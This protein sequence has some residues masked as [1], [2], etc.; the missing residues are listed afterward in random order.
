MRG[1][2]R[3]IERER[4]W[5]CSIFIAIVLYLTLNA[6]LKDIL[7]STI[8]RAT[9]LICVIYAIV[10][11]LKIG[12]LKNV[13]HGKLVLIL[14]II[15]Q[16]YIL[17]RG[18][19]DL[20]GTGFYL[21]LVSAST[22]IYILWLI[23]FLP[24]SKY[25]DNILNCF[26]VFS[27]ITIP[28]WILNYGHL[29]VPRDAEQLFIGE[30]IG[31][32]LPFFAAFLILFINKFSKKEQYIIWFIF[33]TYLILMILNARRNIILSFGL[34][35]IGFLVFSKKFNVSKPRNLIFLISIEL[36]IIVLFL[37]P[38]LAEKTFP[39]IFQR[40]MENSREGVETYFMADFTTWNITEKWIGKGLD[41]T[42]YQPIFDTD[43]GDLLTTNRAGIETGY[44]D[45]ILKGG[46]IDVLLMLI[47]LIYSIITG[48]RSKDPLKN[49]CAYFLIVCL[50]DLY[51]TC[52][53]GTLSVKST[54]MYFC[55]GV[56]LSKDSIPLKP[57]RNI[58]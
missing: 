20:Q 36:G 57:A 33:I 34:Y 42:Y 41:A 46:Y 18:N 45:M 54:L 23:T 15:W 11:S 49:R 40:G 16:L 27:L 37:N 9:E 2:T 48:L 53:L 35:F 51:T 58:R 8:I 31:Q 6:F 32:Y 39:L 25:F 17:L 30:S 56:C 24:L 22:L 19:F 7:T 52:L 5:L 44:L 3:N 13:A 12:R 10:V 50:I 1:K 29:I 4:K 21:K 47:L 55:V 38:E 43:T 14:V 28:L 26:F